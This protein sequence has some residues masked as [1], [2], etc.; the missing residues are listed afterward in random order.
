MRTVLGLTAVLASTSGYVSG[1]ECAFPYTPAIYVAISYLF[2]YLFR[3]VPTAA[4]LFV[5]SIP[6]IHQDPDRPLTI[7]AGNL[8]SDPAK[9][10]AAKGK[11]AHLYFVKV[12]NRRVADR[13]RIMFWFNVSL[14][15]CFALRARGLER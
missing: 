12:N 9:R 6:D 1:A 11:G 5:P 8:P 3:P 15:L 4:E 7:H 13:E 2:L 14:V 10:D